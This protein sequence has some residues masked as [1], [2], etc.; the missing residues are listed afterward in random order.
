MYTRQEYLNGEV[1]ARQYYGQFVTFSDKAKAKELGVDRLCDEVEDAFWQHTFGV[2][3]PEIVKKI[4]AAGDYPSKQLR[5]HVL[6]E[7]ARQIRDF[8]AEKL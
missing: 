3:S 2:C 1:T 5:F 4:N 7:A 6:R 8:S